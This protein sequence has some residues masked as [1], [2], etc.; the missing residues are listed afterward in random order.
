MPA[1]SY[2][3]VPNLIGGGFTIKKVCAYRL[4]PLLTS[5]LLETLPSAYSGH[6]DAQSEFFTKKRSFL[7]RD[8]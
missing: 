4:V 5:T 6:R 3:V 7:F 8:F 1:Q 2:P